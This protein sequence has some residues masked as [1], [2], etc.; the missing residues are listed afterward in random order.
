MLRHTAGAI[1]DVAI[2]VPR[3]P[4][5]PF[6]FACSSIPSWNFPIQV[7]NITVWLV[8]EMFYLFIFKYL[9]LL[10]GCC[11]SGAT[12]TGFSISVHLPHSCLALQLSNLIN[13]TVRLVTEFF[14]FYFT[15]LT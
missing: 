15:L 12:R 3:V 1:L 10:L 8:T 2:Y 4:A 11:H 14:L 6:W 9:K 13:I 7:I 5:L